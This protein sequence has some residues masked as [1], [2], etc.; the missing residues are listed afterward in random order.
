MLTAERREAAV[1]ADGL[2]AAVRAAEAAYVA[3]NPKSRAQ[4]DAACRAMPGGNTRSVLFYTPFP[5]CIA[6][7]EGCHLWDVDGHDYVDLLGE[8]TAGLFGHSDPV[9]RAAIDRALDG[10]INLSGHNTLA[11][12]LAALV[13]ERYHSS[14]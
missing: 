10:G 9:I 14:S 5:V 13:C 1:E 4:Y 7:G 6:R 11:P 3:R 8:F 12:K 2:A